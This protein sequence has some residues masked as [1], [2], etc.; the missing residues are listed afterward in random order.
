MAPIHRTGSRCRLHAVCRPNYLR[1]VTARPLLLRILAVVFALLQSASPAVAAVAD[2]VLLARA[3]G[4]P[5]VTH[6]EDR[7]QPGCTPVHA[8]D[9]AICQ[10]VTLAAEPVSFG[11]PFVVPAAR[12]PAAQAPDVARA[13]TPRTRPAARA[14]PGC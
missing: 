2:G 4:Q 12:I 6:V 7:Q 9:C 5:V 13:P 14:P 1:F 10:F 3:G 11:S 8:A